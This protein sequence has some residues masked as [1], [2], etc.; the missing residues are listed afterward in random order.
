MAQLPGIRFSQEYNPRM[1]VSHLY[2]VISGVTKSVHFSYLNDEIGNTF[3]IIQHLERNSIVLYDRLYFCRELVGIHHRSNNFF[4]ARCKGGPNTYAEIRDLHLSQT[5]RYC[6]MKLDGATVYLYKIYNKKS[7]QF[8]VF[9]TNLPK[10]K[11]NPRQ[12]AA[13][14]LRRWDIETSF[15]DSTETM[16][17]EQWHSETLNGVLQELFVHYWLINYSK[18]QMA[19]ASDECEIF[20]LKRRYKK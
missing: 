8:A 13:L 1:F 2:E 3:R 20:T 7:K 15:R 16:K 10:N 18:I 5:R 14:Y 12:I 6:Q 9:A 4:I 17:L 11:F 19:L